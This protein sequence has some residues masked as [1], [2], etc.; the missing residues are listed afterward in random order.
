[1]DSFVEYLK[2]D[3]Y[4]QIIK[5]LCKKRAKCASKRHNEILI[6][7]LSPEYSLSTKKMDNEEFDIL[8]SMMPARRKWFHLYPNERI[9]NNNPLNTFD[10]NKLAILKRIKYDINNGINTSYLNNLLDFCKRVV[11]IVESPTFSFTPPTTIPKI[12]KRLKNEAECRPISI[13]TQLEEY[14]ILTLSNK[15]LTEL[16]DNNFYEESLAFRALRTYHGQDGKITTHHD[17][18]KTILNFLK[19]FDNRNIYVAECD[20]QKFYDTVGHKVVRKSFYKLIRK[21]EN[22]KDGKTYKSI[23]RI[24]EAYLKCYSFPQNVLCHNHNPQYWESHKIENGK[25]SWIKR[26]D[27]PKSYKN[28]TTFKKAKV[29]IPQ[30]GAL[31]GLI[32]NIV[33]NNV[34]QT[35]SSHLTDHDLYIRYCDDMILLSTNKRRCEEIFKIYSSALEKVHLIPH[36]PNPNY[37]YNRKTFWEC[38]TKTVYKWDIA[39]KSNPEWI[40]FVGYEIRRDGDVRIRKSSLLKEIKKQ[41]DYVNNII[42]KIGKND[43]VGAGTLRESCINHL[44]SMSVGRVTLW[45][46]AKIA[47]EMC[48]INGFRELRYGNRVKSQIK[49]LDYYRNK[50]INIANKKFKKL[51]GLGNATSNKEFKRGKVLISRYGKPFSYYYHF[52]RVAE[53]NKK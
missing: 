14:V 10:Y 23:K 47:N 46:A 27:V 22:N 16:F 34:D 44:I 1:M 15:F 33:L 26:Q 18:I 28:Y 9:K 40:G 4:S 2:A 52:T 6:H 29:G 30:G 51:R 21:H 20:M 17:A 5:V 8:T 13:F 39:Q 7:S 31:S 41:K 35:V 36:K 12:K 38:K 24:I 3:N 32:A 49:E 25:F 11:S 48:W 37:I 19:R 50:T 53:K 42:Q 45:N 43:C